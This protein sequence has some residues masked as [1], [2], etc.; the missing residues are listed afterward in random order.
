MLYDD[1]FPRL[2][3]V[4]KLKKLACDGKLQSVIEVDYFDAKRDGWNATQWIMGLPAMDM[5]IHEEKPQVQDLAGKIVTFDDVNKCVKHVNRS[6]KSW[7]EIW[8]P[9]FRIIN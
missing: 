6:Q 8:I 7:L 2:Q 4:E 1:R 9:S 3:D 5:L